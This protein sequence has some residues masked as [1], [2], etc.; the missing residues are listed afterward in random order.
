MDLTQGTTLEKQGRAKKTMMWFAM[1]SMTMTFAGL[2]SA[3]VVS[4]TRKDWQTD[5]VFPNSFII[6]ALVII[7]SS[8]SLYLVKRAIKNDNRSLATIL[9]VS[10]T[11]LTLPTTPYV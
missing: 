11:H 1:I 8:I 2:T 3:Y 5:L 7:A 9:S 6:S 4:K 10:Y